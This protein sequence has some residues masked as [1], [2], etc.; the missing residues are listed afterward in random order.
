M[1]S[2][3]NRILHVI[4]VSDTKARATPP[5]AD[6]SRHAARHKSQD[7]RGRGSKKLALVWLEAH[8]ELRGS[9]QE[10]AAWLGGGRRQRLTGHVYTRQE[11]TRQSG[12]GLGRTGRTT[13]R[14]T[15]QPRH[16]DARDTDTRNC[17]LTDGPH[18]R[19]HGAHG[20]SRVSSDVRISRPAPARARLP[21]PPLGVRRGFLYISIL[22]MVNAFRSYF[23]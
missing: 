10:P 6:L 3:T 21:L 20:T 12:D 17:Q 2:F 23:F 19:A 4:R 8:T 7:S 1:G 5:D 11:S 16:R 18:A 15:V 14:T 13:W 22:M 9:G